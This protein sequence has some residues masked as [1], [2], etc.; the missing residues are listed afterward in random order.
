MAHSNFDHLHAPRTHWWLVF[1]SGVLTLVCGTIGF[2]QLGPHESAHGGTSA[3]NLPGALYSALQMLILHTPHFEQTNNWVEFGRWTGAF[4]LVTSSLFLLWQRLRHEYLE[5]AH[6]LWKG[7]Y[8]ICGL[9]DRGFALAKHLV[10]NLHVKVVVIDPEP[11]LE[12]VLD[13][14][15]YGM[16]V[17]RRDATNPEV[18]RS[19]RLHAAREI[20]VVTDSDETNVRIALAVTAL[21]KRGGAFV[22]RCRVHLSDIN[23]RDALQ[24]ATNK[25]D[26]GTGIA[27]EYFDVFEREAQRILHPLTMA[28]EGTDA[29]KGRGQRLVIL[30]FG[31]MGR[32]LA[33]AATRLSR[34]VGAGPRR[35]VVID[36]EGECQRERFL[37]RHPQLAGQ[38]EF[39]TAEAESAKA[40]SWLE[41]Y[42]QE[43]ETSLHVFVCVDENTRA[44]EISLRLGE[45]L[46]GSS[47]CTLA[48]RIKSRESLAAILEGDGAG[49][50][51]PRVKIETF[52][53]VEDW[54]TTDV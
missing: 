54:A 39:K 11:D 19:A 1:T 23:L 48:V 45:V 2:M 32:S 20:V 50:G 8:V 17:I 44:A 6:R 38:L 21:E 53:M 10:K 35:I 25:L 27:V 26:E 12:R 22:R 14:E 42:T 40:L 24:R 36:R 33:L 5:L 7:H 51:K 9:G 16:L 28:G 49:T 31:R 52:G 46:A 29:D 3:A 13:C 34:P 18:L 47:G 41:A 30:G 4:T 15:A 43:T 37:F